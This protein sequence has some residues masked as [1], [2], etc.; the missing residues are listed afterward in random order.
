MYKGLLTSRFGKMILRCRLHKIMP[1]SNNKEG[2]SCEISTIYEQ[3]QHQ[4]K[5]LI[6]KTLKIP[7]KQNFMIRC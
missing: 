1:E 2:F 5:K 4:E 6:I 7:M 3:K